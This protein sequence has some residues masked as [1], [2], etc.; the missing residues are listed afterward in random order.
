[1]TART[2]YGLDTPRG[3]HWEAR[4]ACGHPE[5]DPEWWW[6]VEHTVASG[7][8]RLAVH[9]CRSDC[10][11]RAQCH[12]PAVETPQRHP[13]V[14]GGRRYVADGGTGRGRVHAVPMTVS[15]TYTDCPYCTGEASC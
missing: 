9:I 4:A 8:T 14:V 15:D 13:V 2:A 6:P 7:N 12:A 5:V 3:T 1:M 10:P 11:V